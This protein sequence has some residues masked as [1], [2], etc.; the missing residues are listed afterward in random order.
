MLQPIE[1][2][3]DSAHTGVSLRIFLDTLLDIYRVGICTKGRDTKQ[4]QF[5]KFSEVIFLHT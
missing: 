2:C 1:C 3:V 4:Y 5:F